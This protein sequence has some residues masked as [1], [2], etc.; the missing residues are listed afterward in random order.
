MRLKTKELLLG[1]IGKK[2]ARP[3]KFSENFQG[4]R[5]V[6]KRTRFKCEKRAARRETS[7]FQGLRRLSDGQRSRVLIFNGLLPKR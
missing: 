3:R 6:R 1:F 2:S 5:L 4:Q 7:D